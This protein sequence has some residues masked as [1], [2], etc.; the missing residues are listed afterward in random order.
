MSIRTWNR[1]RE[2]SSAFSTFIFIC[3]LPQIHFLGKYITMIHIEL[4]CISC[5]IWRMCL[6]IAQLMLTNW[7]LNSWGSHWCWSEK[8]WSSCCWA[9]NEQWELC[10][11]FSPDGDFL[12][13]ETYLILF[14]VERFLHWNSFLS[15][16]WHY[17]YEK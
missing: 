2:N 16:N 10:L 3:N 15:Y 11:D 9:V 13:D 8:V 5:A 14:Q 7:Y 12:S 6:P 17:A 1:W 4:W